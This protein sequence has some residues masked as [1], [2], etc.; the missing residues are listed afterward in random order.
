MLSHSVALRI[1]SVNKCKSLR[2]ISGTRALLLSARHFSCLF[3]TLIP[4]GLVEALRMEEFVLDGPDLCL[5]STLAL[6][7]KQMLDSP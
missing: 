5:T 3:L 1:K 4:Q 6:K 7:L 2:T